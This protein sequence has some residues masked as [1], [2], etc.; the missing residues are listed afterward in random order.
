MACDSNSCIQKNWVKSICWAVGILS[1]VG[2]AGLNFSL[3]QSRE[4][5]KE[6]LFAKDKA[7]NVAVLENEMSHLRDEM[8]LVN[9]KL[10][11]INDIKITMAEMAG[12]MRLTLE[13][14]D[15]LERGN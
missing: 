13:K 3:A 7:S 4:A 14:V 5:R 12:D 15:N 8:K 9:V 2:G 11:S 10:E 6:A 1:I